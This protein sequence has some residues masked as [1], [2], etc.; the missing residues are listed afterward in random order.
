MAA[1]VA[2]NATLAPVLLV[3]AIVSAA[4]EE[5]PSWYAKVSWAGLTVSAGVP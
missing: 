3:S 2:V 5:V 1:A 4:G